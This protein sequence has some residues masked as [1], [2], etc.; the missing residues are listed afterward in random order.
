MLA[1]RTEVPSD[2]IAEARRVV[3]NWRKLHD[4]HRYFDDHARYQDPLHDLGVERVRNMLQ[5][6][7]A[8]TVLEIGCGYGRLLYHL[9]P[10]VSGVVGIDLAPEPLKKAEELLSAR[11]R[12]EQDV[13]LVLGD[14]ISL[15][16]LDDGCASA[17][18]AFTVFQHMPK[19]AVGRYLSDLRRVVT[20]GGR[21]CFQVA[22]DGKPE[23]YERDISADLPKEQA[24]RWSASGICSV[25]E[26]AG[27]TVQRVE[28][29]CLEETYPGRG[30]SWIWV[31]ATV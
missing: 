5:P 12:E 7:E 26:A 28:R 11:K 22:D 3:E 6:T 19:V 23:H 16:A 18:V 4:G 9:L 17:A 14:G 31:L 27:L 1:A 13:S 30:I 24:T 25:V 8:D 10:D 29:E 15:D 20:P 2:P 21:V